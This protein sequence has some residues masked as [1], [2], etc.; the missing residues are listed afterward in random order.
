M[1]TIDDDSLVILN[2]ADLLVILLTQAIADTAIDGMH[3]VAMVI[4]ESAQMIRE[5]LPKS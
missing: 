5:Q 4:S 2:L 1:S 3:K